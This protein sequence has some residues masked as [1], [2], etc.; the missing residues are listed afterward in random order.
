MSWEA[1]SNES[2]RPDSLSGDEDSDP[3]LSEYISYVKTILGQL[4]RI[5]LAIRK[6]GNKYRFEKAD[7]AL[8][9]RTFEEFRKH[10]T[11][12]ILM[13]FEDSE[14][15]K[16]TAAEK[17]HRASDYDRL[18]PIQRRMVYANILRRNRIEFVTRSRAPESHPKPALQQ[19]ERVAGAGNEAAPE[20]PAVDNSPDPYQPT[21]SITAPP[22]SQTAARDSTRSETFTVAA[23]ATEVGSKLDIKD[24]LAR[25]TSSGATKMTRIGASQAY[26]SCPNFGPDG[27]L[28]C[29]YCDDILPSDFWDSKRNDRWK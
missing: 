19:L 9:E 11:T 10:L 4:L 12:V 18:T 6:S 2:S 16:L 24:I 25:K 27:S 15:Q 3:I 5:S 29:P 1:I 20:L 17:M 28:I 7:A 14:A 26:P 21:P 22:P 23:T 13:A 8:D